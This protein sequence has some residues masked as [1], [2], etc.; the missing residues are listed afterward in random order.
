MLKQISPVTNFLEKIKAL[1]ISEQIE[2]LNQLKKPSDK[3]I[4]YFQRV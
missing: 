2:K 4:E 1:Q 3:I